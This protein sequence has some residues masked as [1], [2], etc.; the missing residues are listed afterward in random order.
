MKIRSLFARWKFLMAPVKHW[1]PFTR[2]ILTIIWFRVDQL[3]LKHGTKIHH[4]VIAM[5]IYIFK[6]GKCKYDG[7]KGGIW[8]ARFER[9][10]LFTIKQISCVSIF[11]GCNVKR[12][13]HNSNFLHSNCYRIPRYRTSLIKIS[14]PMMLS[15]ILPPKLR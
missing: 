10:F 6:K 2:R 15:V 1:L 5:Y 9:K 14:C 8:R 4:P 12:Y 7:G 3:F 13:F 11:R